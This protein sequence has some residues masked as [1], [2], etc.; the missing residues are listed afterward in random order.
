M[1]KHY[2]AWIPDLQVF[3]PNSDDITDINIFRAKAGLSKL[4]T[5]EMAKYSA[6]A[7]NSIISRLYEANETDSKT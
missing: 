4:K 1:S 6:Y 3:Q 7:A 2:A 5:I